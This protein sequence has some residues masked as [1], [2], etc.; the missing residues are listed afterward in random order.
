MKRLGSSLK[1]KQWLQVPVPRSF[2]V[3]LFLLTVGEADELGSSSEVQG[4]EKEGQVSPAKVAFVVFYSNPP[5]RKRGGASDPNETLPN[6][7]E[8]DQDRSKVDDMIKLNFESARLTHPLCRLVILTDTSTPFSLDEMDPPCPTCAG[9]KVEVV[10]AR[11]LDAAE[12]MVS[13]LR[14]RIAFLGQERGT[15]HLVFLDTDMLVVRSL[16]HVFAE[17]FDVAATWRHSA[18]MPV[19]GG[20]LFARL[21]RLRRAAAFFRAMLELSLEAMAARDDPRRAVHRWFGQSDQVAL[22]T[23]LTP[24]HGYDGPRPGTAEGRAAMNT[25]APVRTTFHLRQ[26]RGGPADG[27]RGGGG[28]GASGLDVLLLSCV[29]YNGVG[30]LRNSSR[31]DECFNHMCCC[32]DESSV[33]HFKGNSKSSMHSYWKIA[34]QNPFFFNCAVIPEKCHEIEGT[35]SRKKHLKGGIEG[36]EKPAQDRSGGESKNIVKNYMRQFMAKYS[37]PDTSSDRP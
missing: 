8:F 37:L 34:C 11:G 19:N 20:I 28:D 3:L 14:A 12:E 36:S 24:E 10:R 21:D 27:G 7:A 15:H 29:L 23:L 32:T 22:A 18:H 2:L 35:S 9:P 6:W 5:K 17:P 1:Q 26:G 30:A 31:D 4:D 25:R 16:A 13:R 33:L